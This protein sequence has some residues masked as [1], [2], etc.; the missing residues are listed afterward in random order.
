MLQVLIAFFSV[1]Q[2]VCGLGLLFEKKNHYAGQAQ[3]VAELTGLAWLL[4]AYLCYSIPAESK[5]GKDVALCTSI[6]NFFFALAAGPF[7]KTP[8][9]NI[10]KYLLVPVSFVLSSLTLIAL[11]YQW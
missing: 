6:F 2:F 11:F 5:A 9:N 3:R 7:R 8:I 4:F 1:W 10:E